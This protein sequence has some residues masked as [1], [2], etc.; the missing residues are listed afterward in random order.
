MD[1][2]QFILEHQ[3]SAVRARGAGTHDL[4]R[5]RQIGA[6]AIGG[7]VVDEQRK[8]GAAAACAWVANARGL[9]V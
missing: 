1:L 8:L 5:Y 9:A 7:R 2:S 6:S 3:A 4:L